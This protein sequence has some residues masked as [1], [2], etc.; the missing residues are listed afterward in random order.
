MAQPVKCL[1]L[2]F[3]SG[4]H[5]MVGEFELRIWLRAGGAE[6]ACDSLS[7][8]SSHAHSLSLSLKRNK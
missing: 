3:S 7:A 6:P 2:G 1:T 5:L 4:H 8:S